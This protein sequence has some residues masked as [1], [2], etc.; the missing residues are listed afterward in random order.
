MGMATISC[1]LKV[2]FGKCWHLLAELCTA[3]TKDTSPNSPPATLSMLILLCASIIISCLAN[4]GQGVVLPRGG[5][6]QNSENVYGYQPTC[7]CLYMP[8]GN[9]RRG[10]GRKK[11][12]FRSLRHGGSS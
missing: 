3:A 10:S 7:N 8:R 9:G 12:G 4:I 5:V 6:S 11:E 2:N 1:K